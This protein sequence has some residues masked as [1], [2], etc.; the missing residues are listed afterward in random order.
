MATWDKE[1]DLASARTLR[2]LDPTILVVG[3]GPAVRQPGPVMDQA[4]S[5]AQQRAR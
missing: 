2:S 1:Q 5:R 4:I 3:H